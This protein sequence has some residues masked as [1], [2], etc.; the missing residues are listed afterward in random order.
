M[1]ITVA[2]SAGALDDMADDI[3]LKKPSTKQEM[4]FSSLAAL[5]AFLS[6]LIFGRFVVHIGKKHALMI[7]ALFYFLGYSL[8]AYSSEYVLLFVGRGITGLGLSITCLALSPYISE[9]SP[10]K[11]RG[12]FAS[13]MQ[14]QVQLGIL[15]INVLAVLD[16]SFRWTACI[17]SSIAVLNL[18]FIA[19]APET[20]R[21]LMSR[22][23]VREAEAALDTLMEEDPDLVNDEIEVLQ[24][25]CR[26]DVASEESGR[27]PFF[28]SQNLKPLFIMCVIMVLQQGTA[29][30]AVLADSNRIFRE[31]GFTEPRTCTAGMSAAFLL[32][33]FGSAALTDKA[34]R[35]LL[36]MV[37]AVLIAFSLGLFSLAG[38]LQKGLHMALLTLS[39]GSYVFSFSMAWGSIP[40][41]LS[42]ELFT[43]Q[44]QGRAI[45]IVSAVNWTFNFL[46]VFTWPLL[47]E[48]WSPKWVF[49]MYAVFMILGAVFVGVFL[50]ETKG[51]TLHQVTE[52]FAADAPQYVTV[53]HRVSNENS[54]GNMRG[55]RTQNSQP[56]MF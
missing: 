18:F 29:I 50:P 10:T 33:T 7:S 1:G 12:K 17:T 8:I 49:L 36:L 38:F 13:I 52:L 14:L 9:I 2:Y 22:A 31:I 3:Y 41:V 20:P 48:A 25:S 43:V 28:S 53:V 35:K 23:K 15:V 11:H 40:W 45:S 30:N 21:W 27:V 6:G 32:F 24:R 5:V 37:F 51:L 26:M 16:L 4:M 44:N 46:T 19:I 47:N 34:G 55:A 54:S 42:G 39:L 56:Y